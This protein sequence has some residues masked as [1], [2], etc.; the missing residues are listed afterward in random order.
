M[1]SIAIG[2]DHAAYSFKL[3]VITY[4]Q[5]LGY[6]VKD[7]G[8]FSEDRVDYPDYAIK[9]SEAVA[10]GEFEKGILIC[11]TGVGMSITANKVK[12]VR[13]V[14][15]TEPYSAKMSRE[16]NNANVLCFGARVIGIEMAKMIIDAWIEIE[17]AGGRHA[18]RVAK[19]IS[20][21]KEKR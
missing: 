10:S 4:L 8:P 7:F 5:S 18:D 21:E 14:V 19:I 12:G 17:F 13:A 1:K 2:C 9:V 16:H 3:E 6:E 11:G 15:C 20:Y